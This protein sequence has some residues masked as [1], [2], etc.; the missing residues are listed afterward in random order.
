MSLLSRLLKM[1]TCKSKC[2][3]DCKFNNGQFEIDLFDSKLSEFELKNKD[4]EKLMRVLSKRGKKNNP[5][6][7]ITDV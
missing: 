1:F 6:K 3:S 5:T 4:I 2:V 7:C